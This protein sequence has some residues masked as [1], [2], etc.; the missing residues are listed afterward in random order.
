METIKNQNSLNMIIYIENE[1]CCPVVSGLE[2]ERNGKY[3]PRTTCTR[4]HVNAS[5][6]THSYELLIQ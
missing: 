3:F 6:T 4:S 1:L 2:S 5:I